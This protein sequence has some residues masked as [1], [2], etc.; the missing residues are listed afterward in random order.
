M[1]LERTLIFSILQFIERVP[2]VLSLRP[3]WLKDRFYFC[4]TEDLDTNVCRMLHEK[5]R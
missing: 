4:L 5:F 2:Q 3:S 1:Q